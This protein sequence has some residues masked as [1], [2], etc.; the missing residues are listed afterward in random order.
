M[1]IKTWS[2]FSKRR[3]S[4]KQPAITGTDVTCTLKEAT[5]IENP[6]FV[7]SGNDFTINYVQAFGHYYFVK[8]IKSERNGVIEVSCSQDRLAT[9]KSA[10]GSSS[11]YI[12]RANISGIV[13][14][15]PDPFNPPTFPVEIVSTDIINLGWA[16]NPTLIL[17]V[18]SANGVNYYSM[19]EAKLKS[20]LTHV[21]DPSFIGQFT[22]QFY[23][24]R[25]CMIS[26]KK[27]PYT[28]AGT[29]DSVVIGEHDTQITA[30]KISESII[31]DNA[32]VLVGRPSDNH[33][34]GTT[35]IDTPPYSIGSVYLPYV[36][37]VPVD[38]GILATQRYLTVDYWL[39]QV[40]ADIVYKLSCGSDIIGTYSG[41]CG[42]N[43]PI[44]SQ[45]YNAVG[46]AS[47]AL[48][49]IGGVAINNP[50][51]AASGALAMDKECSMHT[52]INGTISSFIG[53]SVGTMVKACVITRVP[54]DW[55]ID[56]NRARCGIPILKTMTINSISGF[57][58]CKNASV[59]IAGFEDDKEA[60]ESMMNS[61]F[62]YE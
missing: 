57:I 41:N 22:S 53:N 44:A 31:H 2:N 14:Q 19:D 12:E 42:A 58:Q 8:D 3:N 46:V 20:I 40:T 34:P 43:L 37:V 54:V 17:G 55:N 35:Y 7:L 47:A 60:I 11:Q 24:L 1:T 51:M 30:T 62:Y 15:V 48:A 5:S 10:I 4:T 52:Q 32:T 9:Y 38:M 39:D 6:T 49:V 50:M 25:D 16:G 21:F 27:V 56:L 36:G 59:D 26:L 33:E 61:G 13:A 23:G 29:T 28:P 45:N 18:V